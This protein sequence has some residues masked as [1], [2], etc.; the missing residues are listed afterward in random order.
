MLEVE[1]HSTNWSE[2][3]PCPDCGHTTVTVWGYVYKDQEPFAV[4]YARSTPKHP[5]A[6]IQ[7]AL[8]IGG[9]GEDANAEEKR[10]IGVLYG[11]QPE[12]RG[13]MYVD[14]SELPWGCESFLGAMQSREQVVGTEL[15][16]AAGMILNVIHL[17]D[18]RLAEAFGRRREG[19]A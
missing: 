12:A 4:Y 1:Y 8:S 18:A 15:A 2:T 7:M 11:G 13:F 14:A 19:N 10:C 3:G 17:R 6:G 5:E 9:W 16:T